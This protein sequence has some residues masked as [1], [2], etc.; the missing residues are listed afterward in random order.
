MV[1]AIQTAELTEIAPLKPV[2]LADDTLPV[3]QGKQSERS[4]FVNFQFE[5]TDIIRTM[6]NVNQ[7]RAR[8]SRKHSRTS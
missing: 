2:T 8:A 3:T 1:E 6:K 5:D 7:S 4:R